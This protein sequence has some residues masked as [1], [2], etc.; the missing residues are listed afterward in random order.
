MSLLHER[1]HAAFDAAM[2]VVT[3]DPSLTAVHRMLAAHRDRYRQKMSV[4]LVGRV[5]SGKSTLANA[6]LGGD[7]A[8]TGISE[9]TYNVSWLRHGPVP[10]VTVHFSDGRSPEQRGGL[11]DLHALA[12]L[13]PGNPAMRDYLAAISYLEV[14]DPNPR[15]EPF[16]LIDT[17]GLDA[18]SGDAQAR[19]AMEVLGRTP[20]GVQEQ[21][22]RFA[23]RADALVAVFPKAASALD[24][25]LAADFTSAGIGVDSPVT[26]VGVLTKIETDWHWERRP[27][28]M[29]EGR[30][31]AKGL[32]T[33]AGLRN[34]LFEIR[35]LAGKVAA[36]AGVLTDEDFEDLAAFNAMGD[37]EL[38][39]ALKAG[40]I[41]PKVPYPE[42]PLPPER[43][44]ALLVMLSGY[45]FFEACRQIRTG[46]AASPE[47]L[48]AHLAD[49]SGLEDLR[50]LLI[51]H[52]AQRAD[53]IKLRLAI[54]DVARL[55]A[56]LG[57]GP[58]TTGYGSGATFGP[59][60]LD[61]VDQAIAL[62]TDLEQEL[63]FRRLAALRDYWQGGLTFS[64]QEGEELQRISGERGPRL[65][66]RLGVPE[67]TPL[68]E[69]T[70][71][72]A[73]RHDH[74]SRAVQDPAYR[75]S[76]AACD[77]LLSS[78]DEIAVEIENR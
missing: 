49:I 30:R 22:V 25:Q 70:M 24:A 26:A 43:R 48:R 68:S 51:D 32:L 19:K 3:A 47:E 42:L 12:A 50:R 37:K 78:Y 29:E 34:L 58:G 62:V 5:S 55:S 45:G 72:A 40:H 13:A 44:Q 20:S 46:K 41:F 6:L 52:F 76:R 77:V 57:S 60:E 8:P 15:L 2:A 18:A 65:T 28:P 39:T 9:L 56:R 33:Q 74:W 59:R 63:A 27:D 21:T 71:I 35:P 64:A 36:A 75:A 14:T 11:S 67:A 17:P 1:V 31:R 4:A 7:Y 66:D 38:G 16:D 10:D 61:Q 23:S 53:V 54:D 69:L 73:N